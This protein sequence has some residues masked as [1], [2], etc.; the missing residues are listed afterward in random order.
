MRFEQLRLD[1]FGHFADKVID[2]SGEQIHLIHGPN[3]SGK[4][5]IRAAIGELLFGIDERTTYDFR[6][7]KKQLRLGAS[8][9][10][11]DGKRQLDFVR[12]KRRMRSLA[13]PDGTE[14]PDDVLLPFL[15]AM[16]RRTFVDLYVLDQDALRI[17]GEQMLSADGDVGRS[18]FSAS[19]GF[20]DLAAVR[21]ALKQELDAI[22]HVGRK[23]RSTRL[24]Q[25]EADYNEARARQKAASLR[26]SEWDEAKKALAE[27]EAEIRTL[28]EERQ[29]IEQQRSVLDRKLRV[30]LVLPPLDHLRAATETL[31][32]VPD[33]PE[34]FAERWRKAESNLQRAIDAETS[35]ADEQRRL[36][37]ERH[38][39][40]ADAGPLLAHAVAIEDLH[41]QVANISD[42]QRA[43]IK[44]GRDVLQHTERLRDLLSEL[45]LNRDGEVEEVLR[46]IPTRSACARIE[47]LIA[48]KGKIDAAI[49]A[50]KKRRER[51]QRGLEADRASQTKLG[52]PRDPSDA[53]QE[54]KTS[55][56]FGN[57]TRAI[58]HAARQ[59]EE[60]TRAE[61]VALA[62]LAPWIGTVEDLQHAPLP[63]QEVVTSTAITLRRLAE[64]ERQAE[65]ELNKAN[66]ALRDID[67]DLKPLT[68]AGEIPS[69][70]TIEAARRM[71][72]ASWEEIKEAASA[73]RRVEDGKFTAYERLVFRADELVDQHVQHHELPTLLRNRTR[74]QARADQ[75][76]VDLGRARDRKTQK[77]ADWQ[78]L[79][80]GTGWDQALLGEPEVMKAW[81]DRAKEVETAA[82][83]RRTAERALADAQED[84]RQAHEALLRAA[85]LV[86]VTVDRA[87]PTGQLREVVE[88]AVKAARVS[89]E[90][91]RRLKRSIGERETELEEAKAELTN[92]TDE[93]ESWRTRWAE[94]MSAIRQDVSADPDAVRSILAL[95]A[96][97][98]EE[99]AKRSTAQHRL[100]GVIRDLEEHE[101]VARALIN[102]LGSDIVANLGLGEDW[103]RWPGHLYAALKRARET[104]ATIEA[105]DKALG[106]ARRAHGRAVEALAAA[107][108]GCEQLRE[109]A[110]LGA[111]ADVTA[112]IGQSERK[113]Q[114][115]KQLA[116]AEQQLLQAGDGMP[117]D[118]LRSE[119]IGVNVDVTRAEISALADRAVTL[120]EPVKQASANRLAA[121]QHLRLLEARTGFATAAVE[122]NGIAEEI[123]SLAQRWIRLRAST[124]LLDRAVEHYRKANEGPLLQRADEIFAAIVRDRLPDDF[125]GL[126]VDYENPD[127]PTIIARRKNGT[128]CAVKR[129]ST[130]TRDQLWLSLRIAALERRARDVEPM[131]FLADDLFDSSDEARIVAMLPAISELARHTQV[132]L[133]THHAHVVDIAVGALSEQVRVHRL[134]Q[135][136][137][138]SGAHI[139]DSHERRHDPILLHSRPHSSH[140]TSG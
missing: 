90:E 83:A 97:I 67:D 109:E 118:D 6:F 26:K 102:K 87:V 138:R 77:S 40:P 51:A 11:R 30:L 66:A 115:G 18:L 19:S 15:G 98:R 53:E 88:K 64:D 91:M 2:L 72:N 45:G 35:A 31:T 9:V 22:A 65:T 7:E 36:T 23:M 110:G 103:S 56:G 135:G 13:K 123:K 52:E 125:A 47:T 21:E 12:Y 14:F 49:E 106:S 127:R 112:V 69:A 116:E 39:L 100:D 29:R 63:S 50:A 96:T 57:V 46:A 4:S 104:A 33:L 28:S 129:M 74:A 8:I 92:R 48:D 136:Q 134:D 62:R 94:S 44:L 89:W 37:G 25:L 93:L 42:Q 54:W 34:N 70:E 99:Y 73:D 81:L 130:G 113:R 82:D 105:A 124:I 16:D 120:D 137:R 10:T 80:N 111:D 131:P 119:V 101:A 132:L 71:R 78:K 76:N 139:G 32:G 58:P 55:A 121:E 41:Q 1:R 126:E 68:T 60:A 108:A 24:W 27:S 20:A 107:K 79:W 3:A 95:W 133:F 17:G 43:K 128:S 59:V 84:E 122:V 140:R 114:I 85:E 61:A 5:T 86:G 75:C 38:A 117:E